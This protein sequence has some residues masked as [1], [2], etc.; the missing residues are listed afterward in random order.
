M[1]I[2]KFHTW[3]RGRFCKAIHPY[4][5]TPY[6]HIYIDLN[7]ILHRLAYRAQSHQH[8]IDLTLATL[9]GIYN[10][11]KPMKT[12]NIAGDGAAGNAKIA[13][14]KKRRELESIATE[15]TPGTMLM[16]SLND[17]LRVFASKNQVIQLDLSDNS[18]EAEFK[19]CRS[20]QKNS[21]DIRDTHIV[22][23]ND[24]DMILI[25]MLQDSSNN[26][27]IVVQHTVYTDYIVSIDDIVESFMDTY[28]YSLY[29]RFDFVLISLLCG[30]DYFPK[31]KL[32]DQD[33]LFDTYGKCIGLNETMM[34]NGKIHLD[35]FEK[36]ISNLALRVSHNIH[37]SDFDSQKISQYLVGLQWCMQLYTTGYYTLD[38]M[39]TGNSVHPL[40]IA[41]YLA[42]NISGEIQSS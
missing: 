26:I 33:T 25:A 34:Q 2:A 7:N 9:S 6:Q 21:I 42:S 38:Y 13:L 16:K 27:D 12:M 14:Q 3:L 11:H 15:I 28:G 4:E 29:K 40:C 18:D 22:F 10:R 17:A 23:S 36:Y 32:L 1:G 19:I 41:I 30:N 39:Y 31:I 37:P 24:A 8:L 20:I 5:H 35:T